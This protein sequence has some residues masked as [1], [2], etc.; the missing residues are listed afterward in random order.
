MKTSIDPQGFEPGLREALARRTAAN[1]PWPIDSRSPRPEPVDNSTGWLTAEAEAK[2]GREAEGLPE[3]SGWLATPGLAE[4][5][6]NAADKA[7]AEKSAEHGERI[8]LTAIIPADMR[9]PEH[10]AALEILEFNLMIQFGG[11]TVEKARGGWFDGSGEFVRDSSQVY[12]CSF[13]PAMRDPDQSEAKLIGYFVEAGEALGET[14]LHI[15]RS[16]FEACHR[17]VS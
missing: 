6:N 5:L 11:Y 17:K 9:K 15:E 14:W 13:D 4:A 7:E 1:S 8:K 2:V 16:T 3:R 12:S 10:R